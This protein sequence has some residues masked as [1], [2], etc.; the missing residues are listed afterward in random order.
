MTRHHLSFSFFSPFL[1]PLFSLGS[2]LL[3]DA[4]EID[5]CHADDVVA[6]ADARGDTEDEGDPLLGLPGADADVPGAE[7]GR[8]VERP[9]EEGDHLLIVSADVVPAGCSARHQAASSWVGELAVDISSCKHTQ[10]NTQGGSILI[11]MQKQP[12]MHASY[13]AG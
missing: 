3:V 12:L 2:E 11:A 5:H 1:S 10:R 9:A 7:E 13:L 8:G 4:E 6:C